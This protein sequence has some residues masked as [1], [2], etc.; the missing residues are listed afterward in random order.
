MANLLRN[1]APLPDVLRLTGQPTP[2]TTKLYGKLKATLLPQ[3]RSRTDPAPRIMRPGKGVPDEWFAN[4]LRVLDRP[5]A[6]VV[7]GFRIYRLPTDKGYWQEASWLAVMHVV[8]ATVTESGNVVYEDPTSAEEAQYIFV[9]SDRAHRD[10]TTEQILSGRWLMGSVVGGSPRFCQAFI[11]HE[12]V[13]GRQRSIVATTPELMN[14]K[15]NVFVRMLP[16]FAEWYRLREYSNG[17][18]TQAELMGSPVFNIGVE[19][20]EDDALAAYNA[21]I[22]NP[23]AYIDGLAG[24]KLELT[25]RKKLMS[26][27]VSIDNVKDLFF[28]HFDNCARVVRAAQAKRLTQEFEALGF[29]TLCP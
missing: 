2:M 1:E 4:L 5:G 19:L 28:E 9:P 3:L 10:L 17:I 18:E 29:N 24:L 26:G 14:A 13:H 16:H 11:A 21:S 7:R 20:S 6:A 15:S 12:Q 23:E 8:I 25:C 27:D 22:D